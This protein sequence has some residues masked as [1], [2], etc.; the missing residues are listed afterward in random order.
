MGFP[1]ALAG[2]SALVGL[3]GGSKNYNSG[4][5]LTQ[6]RQNLNALS[7]VGAA[8]GSLANGAANNYAA[9]N[10]G[11]RAALGNEAQYLETDPYTSSRDA[12]DLAAGTSGATQAYQKA[13]SDLS[14]DLAARGIKDG[15]ILGG[16]LAYNAAQRAG[17]LA[18]AQ[19]ELANNKINARNANTSALL[20]LYSGAANQDWGRQSDALG[21][22]GGID[23]NLASNYLDLGGREQQEETASKLNVNSMLGAAG[24]VAGSAY[25]F[26][27][28]NGGGYLPILTGSHESGSP[29]GSAKGPA[30][31]DASF[32]H[33]NP[34][35]YGFGNS[36][37]APAIGDASFNNY[38]F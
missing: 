22:E 31:G 9:D 17:S 16:G 6:G 1:A 34:A 15:S 2:A 12:A 7:G 30:I 28:P 10:T 25:G 35:P 4:P 5:D 37:G 24:S 29:G 27:N 14:A 13:N 32:N 38:P 21:A 33:Y 11:Y 23:Q 36:P 26:K 19:N 3:L 20:N 18:S 8:Y